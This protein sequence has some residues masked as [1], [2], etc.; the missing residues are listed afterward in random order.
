MTHRRLAAR[1]MVV[2]MIQ[3][4]DMREITRRSYKQLLGLVPFET[5]Q[6]NIAGDAV[7]SSKNG[8]STA[9]GACSSLQG[10]API[11]IRNSGFFFL[12]FFINMYVPYIHN[13]YKSQDMIKGSLLYY[14]AILRIAQMPS[15]E[16]IQLL[17]EL[18]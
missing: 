8:A 15:W 1:A 3:E 10:W 16:Y 4:S 14:I 7:L 17:S 12:F 2:G 9:L 18:A 5:R 6:C 13:E 11:D